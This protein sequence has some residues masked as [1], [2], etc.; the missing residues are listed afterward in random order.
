MKRILL[1]TLLFFFVL[2]TFFTAA[3]AAGGPEF[4]Y[5]T[6][7]A[8]IRLKIGPHESIDEYTLETLG[9]VVISTKVPFQWNMEIDNS[10][11]SRTHLNSMATARTEGAPS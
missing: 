9:A 1:S 3:R 10:E 6:V 2:S 11:G 5:F 7:S 4:N 8:P